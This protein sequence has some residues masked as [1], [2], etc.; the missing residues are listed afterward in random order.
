MEEADDDQSLLH[1][2]RKS[3]NSNVKTEVVDDGEPM[4]K[5]EPDL[6]Y[7]PKIILNTSTRMKTPLVHT[8]LKN[9]KPM[10]FAGRIINGVPIGGKIIKVKIKNPSK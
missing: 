6:Q 9:C 10:M 2:L 4:V 3:E 5:T 7:R 8:N 1:I